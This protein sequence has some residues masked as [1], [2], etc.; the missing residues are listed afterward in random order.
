MVFQLPNV[1]DGWVGSYNNFRGLGWVQRFGVV[2]GFKKV[3]H[4]QDWF[5]ASQLIIALADSRNMFRRDLGPLLR[6]PKGW[7]FGRWG[8]TP[9][10]HLES[11]VERALQLRQRGHVGGASTIRQFGD[12]WR[13]QTAFLGV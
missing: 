12:I 6:T 11:L 9:P 2:L 13:P 4:V 8:L 7:R 5:D 1:D 3:P 10:H